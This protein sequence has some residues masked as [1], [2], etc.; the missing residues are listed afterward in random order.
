MAWREGLATLAIALVAIL[1]VLVIWDYYVTA[2]WTRDGA[3]R[4]QVASVAPQISGQIMQI[5]VGDNQYVHKGDVLYVIDPFDFETTL[6]ADQAQLRQ[7]AADLQVKQMQSVRRQQLSSLATTPEEQQTY[8]GA[9]IAWLSEGVGE[10]LTSRPR[11]LLRVLGKVSPTSL[12]F[13][14]RRSFP[15]RRLA[16]RPDSVLHGRRLKLPDARRSKRRRQSES[17]ST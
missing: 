16:S 13:S 1:M 17:V 14:I 6:L 4:V 7:K 12:S 3:V 8:A 9:A 15:R 11:V 5:R 10:V 2:P